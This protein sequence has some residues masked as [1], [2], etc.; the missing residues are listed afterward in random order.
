MSRLFSPGGCLPNARESTRV[1]PRGRGTKGARTHGP[2]RRN[3]ENETL[4]F[5]FD[6]VR[7]HSSASLFA[8]SPSLSFPLSSFLIP[9]FCSRAVEYASWTSKRG[10]ESAKATRAS[11]ERSVAIELSPT[12]RQLFLLLASS[13]SE[14]VR[15]QASSSSPLSPALVQ[16]SPFAFRLSLS[17]SPS[18]SLTP[19]RPLAL[20]SLPHLI[21]TTPSSAPPNDE[22]TRQTL[23]L[24]PSFV[25]TPNARNEAM[26]S[27]AAAFA[28]AL[29]R[30]EKDIRGAKA[31]AEALLGTAGA[32]LSSPLPR[33]FEDLGGGRA[34][35]APPGPGGAGTIGGSDF[36]AEDLD[37]VSKDSSKKLEAEVLAPMARWAA[38][39]AAVSARMKRLEGVRLEVDSRRRTVVALGCRIDRQRLRLPQTRSKG[40]WAMEQ[41]IKAM[42]HKEHKLAAARGAFREQEALVFAQLAQLIRDAV[43]LKSYL[44]AVMRLQQESYGTAAGS[45]GP[46]KAALGASV[47]MSAA[48]A[49][50]RA[51]AATASHAR[52]P[53]SAGGEYDNIAAVRGDSSSAQQ[54]YSPNSRVLG[55]GG[56]KVG[57]YA[58]A[59]L[60]AT[61]GQQGGKE[62]G[63]SSAAFFAA[64]GKARGG[65]ADAAEAHQH[66]RAASRGH[67][68]YGVDAGA[69]W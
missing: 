45:L 37:A 40:E 39:F 68:R 29:K 2:S 59:A 51:A 6:E 47:A 23:H 41:S 56:A 16:L 65:T 18:P 12:K 17:P 1:F 19:L 20:P 61:G 43:W 24:D 27:E 30:C 60:P 7:W 3:N 5:A 36:C 9:L 69:V 49:A 53:S 54:Q 14:P 34:A 48:A 67:D 28:V 13:P 25:S 52:V 31:A 66:A 11:G 46:A 8:L 44:A 57:G 15:L 26:L 63:A 64:A 55:G 22:Q 10:R 50:E 58:A 21:E 32:V 38:A 33:V 4:A 35:P 62:N 42:Q